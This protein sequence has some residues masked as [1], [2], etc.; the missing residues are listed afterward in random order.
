[1]KE[2][3]TITQASF[4]GTYKLEWNDSTDFSK[5]SP[6]RQVYGILFNE[7]GEMVIVR[8]K[9]GGWTLPGGG[10][11]K[12]ET[13]EETLIREVNEEVDVDITNITPLGY[14]KVVEIKGKTRSKPYYALRYAAKIEKIKP[15]TPDPAHKVILERKFIRTKDFIKYCSW[16]K[17][18]Q[19][20]INK[21]VA[22]KKERL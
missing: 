13:P 7:K 9:G 15:Q 4:S 8:K 10:P 19:H 16:G 22:W 21:A 17:I 3:I 6:I 11:E 18:A 14:Q 2:T 12:D 1:M 20:V 5:I